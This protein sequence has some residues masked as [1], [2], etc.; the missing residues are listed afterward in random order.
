MPD[1]RPLITLASGKYD[2]TQPLLHGLVD[3]QG[4]RLNVL[5]NFP[6]VDNIFRRMLRLEFDAAEMSTAHYLIGRQR[7]LP[8]V[9]VPVFVNRL[10]P[11]SSFYRNVQTSPVA[12][13]DLAG[14][15]I[16]LT[17]YQVSRAIWM[18]G[19]LADQHGVD[20]RGVTWVTDF[21]EKME[22][23][24]PGDIKLE[25]APAGKSLGQLLAAGEL[26]AAMCWDKPGYDN[27]D[28][29]FPDTRAEEVRYFR[30]T[31]F[32]PI[33][34]TVALR[35]DLVDRYPWV[36]R[37]V[38]EAYTQSKQMAYAWRNKTSGGSMPF[39]RYLLREQAELMGDDPL[40]FDLE[41]AAPVLQTAARYAWE[42]GFIDRIDNVCDLWLDT[43][44]PVE[45]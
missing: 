14:K 9:A 27:V 22:V 40:P 5:S 7:G 44:V 11:H 26:D 38:V 13:S 10:F 30:A 34:H 15:R 28:W 39:A 25:R 37:C 20:R 31:G 18:R 8:I 41:A 23:A 24:V 35:Q 3:V 6:S 1:E 12:A 42:D 36:P 2:I 33:M 43:S 29:F 45:V 32:L 21:D 19:I 16:G 4:I 17:Q